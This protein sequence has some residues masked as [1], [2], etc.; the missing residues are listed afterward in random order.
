MYYIHNYK[1]YLSHLSR[2]LSDVSEYI[3]ISGVEKNHFFP[4]KYQV[5]KPSVQLNGHV[6]HFGECNNRHCPGKK[7]EN[8]HIKIKIVNDVKKCSLC[9]SRDVL[10][11]TGTHILREFFL[12]RF[13][14]IMF[15]NFDKYKNGKIIVSSKREYYYFTVDT[16]INGE[17]KKIYCLVTIKK[18]YIMKTKYEDFFLED[19][20][21]IK[22][23][24]TLSIFKKK[25]TA[26]E[27]VKHK[28]GRSEMKK[29]MQ[30][31]KTKS[32]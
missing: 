14:L 6:T 5:E 32:Q 9:G 28:I 2:F 8:D 20:K 16:T 24:M 27:L 12:Q 26:E 31:K 22:Y 10:E 3:T 7:D 21:S 1:M 19:V 15:K 4:R 30:I 17:V 11:K 13:D 29:M 23:K 25:E 18:K